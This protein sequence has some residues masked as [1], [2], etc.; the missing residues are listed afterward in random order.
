MENKNDETGFNLLGEENSPKE[1]ESKKNENQLRSVDIE[2]VNKNHEN[3]LNMNQSNIINSIGNSEP[4]VNEDKSNPNIENNKTINKN[5][6]DYI[7]E[8]KKLYNE[9]YLEMKINEISEEK[10]ELNKNDIINMND[11]ELT[12]IIENIEKEEKN[13]EHL[14]NSSKK[15][16]IENEIKVEQDKKEEENKEEEDK[17]EIIIEKEEI[18]E[19]QIN[20]QKEKNKIIQ[21]DFND[22]NQEKINEY[23][24]SNYKRLYSVNHFCDYYT[25]KEW[26]AGFITQ[27]SNN[28]LD[29]FDATNKSF[30]NSI[31][32]EQNIIMDDSEN[33]SYFRKYSKPNDYMISGKA[34]N[35]KNK[36]EQFTNFYQNFSQYFEFC[37]DYDFYY[38]L[39]VTVYY[40]LDFCM[41]S[42]I[43]KNDVETSF[44]LIL[45]ILNIICECLK[46]IDNNLEDFLNYQNEIKNDEN[47]DYV[48]ISKKHAI[49]SFFDDIYFLI[50][51]IFCNS[52][53]YLEWYKKFEDKINEFNPSIID[54][55]KTS[56][57]SE[58][59][60][61]YEDQKGGNNKYK[62]MKRT[63]LPEVYNISHKFNTFDKKISSCI[64]AY[65]VDYFNCIGGYKIL[66]TILTSI[67]HNKYN[68]ET[69]INIQNSIIDMLYTAK[70]ITGTFLNFNKKERNQNEKQ[71]EEVTRM[72]NYIDNYKDNTDDKAEQ[73]SYQPYL[74]RLF[75]HLLDL[76]EQNEKEKKILKERMILIDLFK[77]LSK[78][79]K[80]EKNIILITNLNNVIKSVR[81]NY[82]YNEI[83]ENNNPD[84]NEDM[85]NDKEFKDRNMGIE[86]MTEEYFCQLCKEN[87]IIELFLD[88]QKTHEEI[89]KRLYPLIFIIYSNISKNK[90]G[91]RIDSHYIFDSL[92]QKLKESEQNNESLW[93]IIL[94][95]II[96]KISGELIQDDKNYV[97]ELIRK[98]FKET[99]IKKTS[100]VI[101]LISFMINYTLKCIDTNKIS[102]NEN[103]PIYDNE[104]KDDKYGDNADIGKFNEKKFFCLQIL[105]NHLVKREIIDEL[106]IN[107]E[108]KIS[109]IDTCIDGIIEILK[110]YNFDENIV[111]G[112]FIEIIGG[113][114]SSINIVE[115]ISLLEKIFNLVNNKNEIIR[116]CKK[117]N[118]LKRL[119]N[120]LL[121]YLNNNKDKNEKNNKKEIEKRLDF[122]FLLL[123]ID[124]LEDFKNLFNELTNF[125]KTIKEIFYSK[126]K[127]N[128][129]N[130]T[131][132]FKKKIC[133]EILLEKYNSSITND[134]ISYQL[135]KELI[136]NI[137]KSENVF[138][139]VNEKEIII[140][141]NNSFEDIYY[142]NSLFDILVNTTNKDIKNDVCNFLTTIYLGIRL[143]SKEKKYNSIWDEII[144]GII[145]IFKKLNPNNNKDKNAIN[146]LISLIKK[147]TEE[148]SKDGDIINKKE[149]DDLFASF[150]NICKKEEEKIIDKKEEEK[151]NSKKLKKMKELVKIFHKETK[152]ELNKEKNEEIS[153]KILLQY[154]EEIY[155]ENLD[156]GEIQDNDL[157]FLN[158][159]EKIEKRT[160]YCSL[161]PGESLFHLRYYISYQFKIPSKCIQIYIGY[162]QLNPD[163][164]PPEKKKKIIAPIKKKINKPSKNKDIEDK[165]SIKTD[166][167]KYNL[168]NDC[169]NI[170]ET[171]PDLKKNNKRKNKKEEKENNVPILIIEKIKNPLN[172]DKTNNLKYAIFENKE[173]IDILNKY[174][175][176]EGINIWN[177][178]N[179]KKE[180][181][182]QEEE[183]KI[184]AINELINNNEN[185]NDKQKEDLLKSL[186]DFDDSNIYYMNYILSI[187]YNNYLQKKND[188]NMIRKFL[189]CYIWK[190]KLKNIIK[191][192]NN[193]NIDD[194]SRNKYSSINE[195]LAEKEYEK[196]I[197]NICKF[198]AN[199]NSD[200]KETLDLITNKI[201][202]IFYNI[203][204]DFISID[205]NSFNNRK[206]DKINFNKI[207]NIYN[208]IL[209]DINDLFENN[210]KFSL[211]FFNLLLNEIQEEN[212][213]KEK[214]EFCFKDGIIKNNCSSFTEKIDKILLV[215]IKNKC[216]EEKNEINNLQK[217]IYLYISSIFY[218]KNNHD[219]IIEMLRELLDN[220]NIFEEFNINKYENNLKIYLNTISEI[221]LII[222]NYIDKDFDFKSY[223]FAK[224]IPSIYNPFLK[225]II[226]DS[227]Y[228][229]C[230][231]GG[232]CL[233]LS[234]YIININSIIYEQILNYNG[235]DIKE[236]LFNDIIMYKCNES[237]SLNEDSLEENSIKIVNS[238]NEVCYLFISIIIKEIDLTKNNLLN[239]S[240]VKHY[241]NKINKYNN[242]ENIK[243]DVNNRNEALGWKL[244]YK[245]KNNSEKFIGLKNLGCTCYM[246]SLLQV[247]YHIIPLRESLLKCDYKDEKK[248][249]LYEVQNVF[250]NLKYL[251]RGY[252]TPLSFANNYDNEKLNIHQQ[253]DVDEFFSN[254][255]NKLENRLMNSENENLIKYFFLGRFS[256]TLTFQ[257]GCNHHRTNIN[258]FYSIQLQVQNKKNIYESLDTLTEGEL[259]NGDNCIFCPKC[260]KK[261]PA[262]KRQLFRTLPRVLMFV[263]KRF[264]FNFD[265]MTKFKIN[266]YYEFPIELD[267][268]KYTSEFNDN[269]NTQKNNIY[270]L[271]SVIVHMGNS[272]GGHYYAFI[273][274]NETQNWYQFN[275]TLVTLF[276]INNLKD[277]TF[278]GKEEG[279]NENKLKSA[280]LLFYEKIDQ[281]NCEI[282]DKNKALNSL[283][284]KNE[285]NINNKEKK[286]EFYLFDE[287]E[288]EKEQDKN[289]NINIIN[290]NY[291]SS[292]TNYNKKSEIRKKNII[293][294][295]NQQIS[296]DYLNEKL[297]SKEYQHFTLELYINILNY[298]DYKEEILPAY[299]ENLCNINNE[300]NPFQNELIIY[301]T[302]RPKGSNLTK[303]LKKGKIKIIYIIKK[304]ENKYSD[305]EK[306]EKIIELFEY[307][308]IEFFNI[309][310][311]CN[312]R[313]YIG[314]YAD[315]IKFLINRYEYCANFFL[316]EF[317]CY[318]T[319]IEYL[320]NCPLY[321]IKKVIV[322]I[323]YYAMIKS[324]QEYT[325]KNQ[326][327]KKNEE[328]NNNSNNNI[329]KKEKDNNNNNKQT[330]KINK[331]QEQNQKDIFNDFVIVNK[332]NNNKNS[333]L[334]SPI[335]THY[336][337]E[338]N[339]NKNK[340]RKDIKNQ[341]S[342]DN[343]IEEDKKEGDK[344][345]SDEEY[346]IKLQK[347]YNRE[348]NYYQKDV[349]EKGNKKLLENENISPDVLRLIYNILYVLKKINPLENKNEAR[350]LFAVL[351]KFSL[352]SKYTRN[353]LNKNVN[354]S[355]LLN[356]IICKDCLYNSDSKAEITNIERGLFEISH[357]ILNPNPRK[358]IGGERDKFGQYIK[359]N[360][361][362]ML[363][364]N[365]MFYKE[366]SKEEVEKSYGGIGT[367][368]WNADY[369]IKLIKKAKTK[370]DINYLS[371]L[372]KIKCLNNKTVFDNILDVLGYFL[373]SIKDFENSFYDESDEENNCDIYKNYNYN[374]NSNSDGLILLRS[375]ITILFKQIIHETRDNLDDYRIKSILNKLSTLFNKYKKF[376]GITIVIVNI[377][378]DIYEEND[379][380]IN[381]TKELN[382]VL[383]WLNKYKV[384]PKYYDIRGIKMYRDEELNYYYQIDSNSK[385]AFEQLETK[386]TNEKIKRINIIKDNNTNNID[387]SKLDCD[388]SDFKF[389]IGD[390][391]LY[392]NKIYEITKC[393]NE[394][395]KIKLIGNNKQENKNSNEK[396]LNKTKKKK[397]E[398][399]KTSLWIETD[400]YKLR[401]KKLINNK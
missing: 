325:D 32:P 292:N 121:N 196:I 216:F 361:D 78:T 285:I 229:D 66:F 321:E 189:N 47:K 197:L 20:E 126:I 224:V 360:Y 138:K 390:Q 28:S 389:T 51:K 356:Y 338:I 62:L 296:L 112:V 178:I 43:N 331:K 255:L 202:D 164:N 302:Y 305:E 130:I 128:A 226:K 312:E 186:F 97:F 176:K 253:M 16:I 254:I 246:N 137:N 341:E 194:M 174:K 335:T 108:L 61:L 46:Y 315:L 351:L 397:D 154:N 120:E 348:V 143:N 168:F 89:I 273:K 355:L 215:L 350:F 94:L 105:I 326:S 90:N 242:L 179:N 398:K 288:H 317:S 287:N 70:V 88:N 71:I 59:F 206:E 239:N 79:Q 170:L 182:Q 27:I 336:L 198:L 148:S 272:E 116:Y 48:L 57:I 378:I 15:E 301:R 26:R 73:E 167:Q 259:M 145:T 191:E 251:K 367:T 368:F 328:K 11:E 124:Y 8:E 214:F 276:D 337:D 23:K 400:N 180:M 392:E 74:N 318:N 84:Y 30:D 358:S 127:K 10:I 313:K 339:P 87:K 231:F 29:L 92:F 379:I 211:S 67:Y 159:K 65:F 282:F 207:K 201:F 310:I 274:D 233:L 107:N 359:L 195:L 257:E 260:N 172:D 21:G 249:S 333:H 278:G 316:E 281:T 139:F 401:I 31:F 322:G 228:H 75:L 342:N 134:Y 12:S 213:L 152:E 365:L 220:G 245:N 185:K 171:F 284:N 353:F 237:S 187:I 352:I 104:K 199:N 261:F 394:L 55:P 230:F 52:K 244:E 340:N 258:D 346:A 133:K 175:E 268:N 115:N 391:V 357:E 373:E 144:G 146:N 118:F 271:K 44:R 190:N 24:N 36:L 380:Y 293:K 243:K 58:L 241:L 157:G 103:I 153:T 109:I 149:V 34:S 156:N 131:S 354:L 395:I 140:L 2:E 160:E 399:E 347:E 3:E 151:N 123:D 119:F 306:Q 327:E 290:L 371:N 165:N 99:G 262:L 192:I 101:Q 309:I 362:Y 372:I 330:Q 266:D 286:N 283:I 381:N 184:K 50:K 6:D 122:I 162:K 106:Q 85:L 364:C 114:I 113:I 63:C 269:K 374:P 240:N 77:G 263:L 377:I 265:T 54:D 69:N 33:I 37:D 280:Y 111:K 86:N 291:N 267:M 235:K 18:K 238:L 5:Q 68:Y 217:D 386:K 248:N 387:I 80:L 129:S 56:S 4:K 91:K 95:D 183:K 300:E 222:Y 334:K 383:D 277:E 142:Y 7:K 117:E 35:L 49:Y 319:I 82:I 252:Y 304:E 9:K 150:N 76:I 382:G 100:K 314:C 298:I 370:Q 209:N 141:Y 158:V 256:D 384:P 98:Y 236:Y 343:K 332:D 136:L 279:S 218:T 38:F 203:I 64:V 247:F 303:Y 264:E 193:I 345:L 212:N 221:L 329:L 83:K 13:E 385:K 22:K 366:K 320:I 42:Y 25:G 393:L 208:T 227:N 369:I 110:K 169:I 219:K 308:L 41:N 45:V 349:L 132:F 388:M 275:D 270:I 210:I 166:S 232:Q 375:N 376:Y 294:E 250:L 225:D 188:K 163:N 396:N 363:L 295:I 14:N 200:D 96:L 181:S 324:N 323:I 147:I 81:F 1:K 177:I 93:K 72:N 344:P 161:Y 297:F 223:I 135:F 204:K 102:Q 234:N 205:F 39:R 40:G 19:N 53:E 125:N 299:L 307:I 17:K 311:R 155:D 289:N 173:L 60:L